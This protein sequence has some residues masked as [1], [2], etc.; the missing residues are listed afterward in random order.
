MFHYGNFYWKN[1]HLT[2]RYYEKGFHTV[3]A[4]WR[5]AMQSD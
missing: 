5:K 4:K 2:K 1:H 3:Q